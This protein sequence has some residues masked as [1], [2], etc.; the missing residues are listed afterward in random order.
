MGK[1]GGTPAP[2]WTKGGAGDGNQALR[3][4]AFPSHL[5]GSIEGDSVGRA[6]VLPGTPLSTRQASESALKSLCKWP[7]PGGGA[8]GV[9]GRGLCSLGRGLHG[10]GAGSIA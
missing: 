7:L 4:L 9:S 10:L 1:K 8:G 2:S 3:P 6:G 5:T